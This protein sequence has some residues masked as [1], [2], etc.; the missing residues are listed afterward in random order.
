MSILLVISFVLLS[1]LA[2]GLTM[3]NYLLL[4]Q[5]DPLV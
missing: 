5:F 4:G 3:A 2:L 1:L